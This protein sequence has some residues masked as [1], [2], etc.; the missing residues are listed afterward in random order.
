MT[1]TTA[2]GV[3]PA[4]HTAYAVL[5][6]VGFCHLLNDMMQSL[7]LALYPI[8]KA[9]FHLN[10]AQIGLVTLAFQ[11]T[12]SLLQPLV[13]HFS[14]LRPRPYSLA[15]GMVFTLTG[16]LILAV[17]GSYP[18]L[19]IA[20]VFIGLGSA[21]FHPE[22]SR[23]ARMASGGRYGLAQSVFQVGGNS[24]QALSPLTAAFRAVW[25]YLPSWAYLPLWGVAAAQAWRAQWPRP[26]ACL[27]LWLWRVPA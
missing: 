11:F 10:F 4:Q 14:D 27:R 17:T 23:V 20:A 15:A 2:N 9:Q 6:A 22:S 24:G 26:W 16:L 21:V 19:L 18:V 25:A 12:A 3:N 13:G 1:D 5:F 7:L 8:L